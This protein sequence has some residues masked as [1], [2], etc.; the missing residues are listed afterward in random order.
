MKSATLIALVSLLACSGLTEQEPAAEPAQPAAGPTEQPQ[1][2]PLS[3][4]AQEWEGVYQSMECGANASGSRTFCSALRVAVERQ[5]GALQ[6]S[7]QSLTNG[8]ILIHHQDWTASFSTEEAIFYRQA[9]PDDP[10][11]EACPD[12]QK[13]PTRM[14]TLK[15]STGSDDFSPIWGAVEAIGY[16]DP[17]VPFSRL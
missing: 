9:C 7:F 14:L 6:I 8:D 16:E 13:Q 5:D 15:R 12:A 11:Q 3:A 17:P 10:L 4:A 2:E 1:P